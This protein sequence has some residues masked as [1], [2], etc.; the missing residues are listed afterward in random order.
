M[1]ES[2]SAGP[3]I[4]DIILRAQNGLTRKLWPHA[5]R[6]GAKTAAGVDYFFGT[7]GHCA[8]GRA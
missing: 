1:W 7:G 3:H 4:M 6:I 5:Y 2:T 8:D